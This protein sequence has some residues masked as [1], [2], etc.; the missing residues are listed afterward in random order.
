ML[1][2]NTL[3][4]LIAVGLS[5]T[6]ISAVSLVV[7]PTAQ[8]QIKAAKAV[9]DEAKTAGIIGETASGYLASVK[10]D[11][12]EDVTNAMNEIN[13][14]RKAVFTEKAREQNVQIDIIAQ[15][16]GEKLV[17]NAARGEWVRDATG[18]WIK[19]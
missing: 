6:A 9:V 7:T 10:G 3:A 5:V 2:K 19:K 17:M 13:I 14:G 16:T 15:L 1:I 8:A 4:T 18:R 11:A 12:P